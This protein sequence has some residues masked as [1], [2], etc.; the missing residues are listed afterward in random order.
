MSGALNRTAGTASPIAIGGPSTLRLNILRQHSQTFPTPMGGGFDYAEA[1]KIP[2]FGGGE[3]GSHPA[4]DGLAGLVARRLWPLRTALHSQWPGTARAP[5]A[6]PTAGVG[7]ARGTQ[8]FASPLNSWPDNANLDKARAASL[9]HQAKVWR[10][11]SLG[12]S[13]DTCWQTSLSSPW[14]SRTLL[15]SAGGSRRCVGAG[16]RHYYWGPE[17]EWAGR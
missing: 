16:G 6:R 11:L 15:A 9:A 17:A 8:R 4:D 12:R 7:A 13:Y 1:F 2:R 5:T 14:A 10:Q 3:E